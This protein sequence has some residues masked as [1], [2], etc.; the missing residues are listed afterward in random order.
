MT[1][2]S[3]D[4]RHQTNNIKPPDVNFKLLTKRPI[5]KEKTFTYL[6]SFTM[7]LISTHNTFQN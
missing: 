1:Q 2:L 3:E 5:N 6:Q 7:Q 4:K